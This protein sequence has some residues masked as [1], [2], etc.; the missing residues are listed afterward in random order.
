MSRNP[1]RLDRR[2]QVIARVAVTRS[3]TY[4]HAT[5]DGRRTLCRRRVFET[6]LIEPDLNDE[7]LCKICRRAL[8]SDR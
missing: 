1:R 8:K 2:A 7:L 3:G 5:T 4:I 6:S